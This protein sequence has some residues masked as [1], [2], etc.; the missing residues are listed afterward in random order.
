MQFTC[1]PYSWRISE[2]PPEGAVADAV[3]K[4]VCECSRIKQ[5]EK[6]KEEDLE[7]KWCSEGGELCDCD[8]MLRYGHTG[9]ASH[10]ENDSAFFKANPDLLRHVS[11]DVSVA[12]GEFKCDMSTF[13][14]EKE[15][16]WAG[17]PEMAPKMNCQCA[18]FPKP[19]CRQSP[20][21][22]AAP[23]APFSPPPPPE[24]PITH[25]PPTAPALP[26]PPHPWPPPNPSPPTFPPVPIEVPPLV[27][28]DPLMLDE[29][30]DPP[31][32]PEVRD[33]VALEEDAKKAE[34]MEEVSI[35]VLPGVKPWLVEGN[36]CSDSG[37]LC[38]CPGTIRYGHAG[39]KHHYE[40]DGAYFKEN[41]HVVRWMMRMGDP[42]APTPCT[43]EKF[44]DRDP[45]PDI[46]EEEKMCLCAPLVKP[47]QYKIS[48][49]TWG[50]EYDS[51]GAFFEVSH[52]GDRY[53]DCA[54]KG[55]FCECDGTVRIGQPSHAVPQEAYRSFWKEIFLQHDDLH[56]VQGRWFMRATDASRGGVQCDTASFLTDYNEKRLTEGTMD[57]AV[58]CQC[59][60]EGDGKDHHATFYPEGVVDEV[61][62]ISLD[63]IKPLEKETAQAAAAAPNAQ[64]AALGEAYLAD[65][66]RISELMARGVT[67]I[68]AL[69]QAPELGR[70][71]KEAKATTEAETKH[72]KAKVSRAKHGSGTEVKADSEPP[73]KARRG[74]VSAKEGSAEKRQEKSRRRSSSVE[75]SAVGLKQARANAKVRRFGGATPT[76]AA[77]ATAVIGIFAA[78]GVAATRLRRSTLRASEE[79]QPLIPGR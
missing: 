13:P 19:A 17:H 29:P 49:V 51:F 74:A 62:L 36:R 53:R 61:Q 21:S 77:A 45:F 37:G 22:P 18:R 57:D 4:G 75:S 14:W 8:G 73:S 23:T 9:L 69:G 78:L 66:R 30:G 1:E 28:I 47:Y 44:G 72:A 20:P 10:Y 55:A 34:L 46:P 11:V 56:K 50:Q 7:Y 6:P 58:R 54:Q 64:E 67:R 15:A 38:D 32:L 5:L 2:D 35:D 70:A 24:A 63:S 25:Q 12:P 39:E 79:R 33:P 52:D 76:K 43:R 3:G 26:P 42:D 31:E 71:K 27:L 59:L 65:D 68:A 60:P 40:D 16:P 48:G 41:P